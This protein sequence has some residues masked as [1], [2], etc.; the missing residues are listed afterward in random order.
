[1]LLHFIPFFSLVSDKFRISDQ[2]LTYYVEGWK[3]HISTDLL[4]FSV[5]NYIQAL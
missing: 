4:N 5:A 2:K 3:R 1:M